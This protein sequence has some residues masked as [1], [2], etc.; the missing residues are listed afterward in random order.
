MVLNQLPNLERSSKLKA[1]KV[2]GIISSNKVWIFLVLST[3][4]NIN[5]AHTEIAE[6]KKTYLFRFSKAKNELIIWAF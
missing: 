3:V 1:E 4:F 6:S 5:Q 2:T